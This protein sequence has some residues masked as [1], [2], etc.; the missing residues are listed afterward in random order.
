M[1]IENGI[2]YDIGRVIYP[3]LI[4]THV[5]AS[6]IVCLA[7]LQV[8]RIVMLP[9]F[10]K[11]PSGP[12]YIS[13]VPAPSLTIRNRCSSDAFHLGPLLLSEVTPALDLLER[14]AHIPVVLALPVI[15]RTINTPG[16]HRAAGR[17]EQPA[18]LLGI[19]LLGGD[20]DDSGIAVRT[21]TS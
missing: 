13:P 19:G 8:K 14:A 20:I 21:V 1:R 17:G 4:V 5:T 3:R 2:E 7:N 16:T 12:A 9:A 18:P 10:G 15:K 11:L 6:P